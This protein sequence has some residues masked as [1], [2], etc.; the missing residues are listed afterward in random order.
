ML[1]ELDHERA[2]RYVQ[3]YP[4]VEA[5]LGERVLKWTAG[6]ANGLAATGV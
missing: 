6:L 3:V 1:E 5:W 4:N 2:Q